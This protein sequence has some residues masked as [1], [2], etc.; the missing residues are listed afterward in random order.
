M[1]KVF[2]ISDIRYIEGDDVWCVEGVWLAKK[3]ILQDSW[4][5]KA[6]SALEMKMPGGGSKK[7]VEYR[8]RKLKATLMTFEKCQLKGL[9]IETWR[10][11]VVKKNLKQEFKMTCSGLCKMSRVMH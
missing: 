4:R 10:F 2:Y 5:D 9:K 6:Q 7:N 8:E 1:L 3:K 11:E